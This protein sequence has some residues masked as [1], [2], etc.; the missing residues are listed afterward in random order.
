MGIRDLWVAAQVPDQPVCCIFIID[1]N[2]E[3]AKNNMLNLGGQHST[4][5]AFALL[6]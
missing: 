1:K 5:V 2:K 4:E 3:L 6:T